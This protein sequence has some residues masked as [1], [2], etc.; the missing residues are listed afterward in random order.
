MAI[1]K[2][3]ARAVR[4]VNAAK[5]IAAARGSPLVGTEHLLLAIVRED[6]D[7]GGIG[8]RALMKRDPKLPKEIETEILRILGDCSGSRTIE[9]PMHTESLR[10]V[11][12]FAV[13]ISDSSHRDR[14][15]TEHLLL[16]IL[17]TD[18][19]LGERVLKTCGVNYDD[20]L[21]LVS[22]VYAESGDLRR[23]V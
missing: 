8:L 16:A 9:K 19:N 2:F 4:L 7:G 11:L 15:G 21:T 10:D 13:A 22:R 5:G 18:K 14:V 3:T 12:Q 6:C 17:Q 20:L 1:K 23:A